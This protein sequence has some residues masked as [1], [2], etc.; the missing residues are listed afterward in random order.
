MSSGSSIDAL[1]RIWRSR[2]KK[3]A[4][5]AWS[6]ILII[7]SGA[8]TEKEIAVREITKRV[9]ALLRSRGEIST[10]NEKQLGWKLRNLGLDRHN[11]GKGKVLRIDREMR[12]RIHQLA[13]QFGLELAKVPDCADCKDPQLIVHK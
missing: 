7:W 3:F 9:N 1:P 10:C 5:S 11:N 13:T 2:A 4:T 12:R 6:I 8:H